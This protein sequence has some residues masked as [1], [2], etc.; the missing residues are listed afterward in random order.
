MAKILIIDD[1]APIREVLS[2]VLQAVGH[3]AV[4]SG[5]GHDALRRIGSEPFDLV[6]CDMRMTPVDGLTV[7]KQ[8]HAIKPDLPFLMLTAYGSVDVAKE[9]MQAGAFNFLS[10]PW[11]M[12]ELLLNIQR[13]VGHEVRPSSGA[14]GVQT[15]RTEMVPDWS[16]EPWAEPVRR[17]AATSAPVLITCSDADRMR[18]ARL[19]HDQGI[20]Q[21]GPFCVLDCAGLPEPILLVEMVGCAKGFVRGI[22]DSRSGMLEKAFGGTLILDEVAWMPHKLQGDLIRIVQSGVVKRMGGAEIIPLDV[23][24]LATTAYGLDVLKHKRSLIPEFL[25]WFGENIL[26]IERPAT[27]D[28]G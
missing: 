18:V 13:A 22:P 28:A 6:L 26:Q 16:T 25:T 15:S 21:A 19:I 23:R 3:V 8:A 12:D 10:K 14:S 7:L 1:E 24:I 2:K 17:L 5:D 20:R 9:S 4:A 27:P 11:K